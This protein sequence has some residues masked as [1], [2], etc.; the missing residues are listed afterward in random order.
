MLPLWAH[1]SLAKFKYTVPQFHRLFFLPSGTPALV[2]EVTLPQSES[3]TVISS[4]QYPPVLIV[5]VI[6]RR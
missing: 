4:L 5:V 1:P 3:C 2:N 6:L